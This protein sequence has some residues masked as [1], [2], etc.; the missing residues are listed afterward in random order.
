MVVAV[1][2]VVVVPSLSLSSG[3]RGGEGVEVGVEEVVTGRQPTTILLSS[4]LVGVVSSLSPLHSK[5]GSIKL[6]SLL[7]LFSDEVE[8]EVGVVDVDVLII[9]V[10][11]VVSF[12]NLIPNQSSSNVNKHLTTAK[13]TKSPK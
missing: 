11:V 6:L 5:R 10:V 12:P 1:V 2:V 3:K 8:V 9:V 13:T 4:S 7:V